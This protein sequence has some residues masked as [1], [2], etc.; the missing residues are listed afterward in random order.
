MDLQEQTRGAVLVL[1]PDGP[2]TGEDADAF[3]AGAINAFQRSIGRFVVDAA[4]VPYGRFT[5][6]PPTS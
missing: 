6:K 3:K 5:G 4:A 1:R 2:L